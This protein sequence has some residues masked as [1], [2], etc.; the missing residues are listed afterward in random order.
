MAPYMLATGGLGIALEGA[1]WAMP[2]FARTKVG[3]QLMRHGL[4]QHYGE[5]AARWVHQV[6]V[7]TPEQQEGEPADATAP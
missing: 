6:F 3:E 7:N 4:P 5:G 2:A 1:R